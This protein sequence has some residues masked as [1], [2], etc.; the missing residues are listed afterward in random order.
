MRELEARF[1]GATDPHERALLADAIVPEYVSH[2]DAGRA[3]E[4]IDSVTEVDDPDLSAR[5]T[6]FR[7]VSVDAICMAMIPIGF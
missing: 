2:G 5:I 7:G 6:A 3:A 1:R 4:F